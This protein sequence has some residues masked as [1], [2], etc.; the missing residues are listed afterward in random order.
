MM[1]DSLGLKITKGTDHYKDDARGKLNR[2]YIC[3][4]L[5][6]ETKLEKNEK[7]RITGL[8]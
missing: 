8:V 2:H 3:I 7:G 6:M 5:K 1:H 4:K